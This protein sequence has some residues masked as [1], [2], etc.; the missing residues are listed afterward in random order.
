VGKRCFGG[1]EIDVEGEK[2]IRGTAAS[3]GKGQKMKTSELPKQKEL[4]ITTAQTRFWL[5]TAHGWLRYFC[6]S[7]P[8]RWTR[9]GRK[10]RTFKK[11]S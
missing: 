1:V 5:L 11:K 6:F 4:N 2:E 10:K 7:A 3:R 9:S 8:A